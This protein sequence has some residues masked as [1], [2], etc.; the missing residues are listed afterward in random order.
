MASV[1]TTPRRMRDFTRKCSRCAQYVRQKQHVA[2]AKECAPPLGS[3]LGRGGACDH[4]RNKEIARARRQPRMLGGRR[5]LFAVVTTFTRR[6][7][8][9]SSGAEVGETRPAMRRLIGTITRGDAGIVGVPGR[10]P[11]RADR[12]ACPGP[13]RFGISTPAELTLREYCMIVDATFSCNGVCAMVLKGTALCSNAHARALSY[14]A[15]RLRD[16]PGQLISLNLGEFTSGSPG[17][18]AAMQALLAAVRVDGCTLG[19][20]YVSE[21]T[22]FPTTK[23]A[24][25]KAVRKNSIGVAYRSRV[26]DMPE[27]ASL[28]AHCWYDPPKAPAKALLL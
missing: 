20:I 8:R 25:R 4:V 19:H 18:K 13:H 21:H 23:V 15:S 2:H 10:V 16:S 14:V 3:A 26:K 1:T 27:V 22:I 6:A 12:R 28:G 24:L 17:M 9:S 7:T 11:S 5:F